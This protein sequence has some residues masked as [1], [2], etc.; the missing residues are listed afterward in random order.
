[1]AVIGLVTVF[2]KMLEVAGGLRA[3]DC[4]LQYQIGYR[5]DGAGAPLWASAV[6]SSSGGAYAFAFNLSNGWYEYVSLGGPAAVP[7]GTQLTLYYNAGGAGSAPGPAGATTAVK[8]VVVP[9]NTA[10]AGA[11][12]VRTAWARLKS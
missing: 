6:L 7:G 8:T 9:A 5:R 10:C 11:L 1:L 2:S 4:S 12:Q 3:S